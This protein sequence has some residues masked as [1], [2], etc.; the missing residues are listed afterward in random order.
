[1]QHLLVHAAP[2]EDTPVL[3]ELFAVVGGHDDEGAA[4]E[5]QLFQPGGE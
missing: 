3:L 2:V 1:V 4:F 5:A